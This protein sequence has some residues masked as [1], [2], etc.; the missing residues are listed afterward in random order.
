MK[1]VTPKGRLWL[2]RV[3][4]VIVVIS[5]LGVGFDLPGFRGV[6][7]LGAQVRRPTVTEIFVHDDRLDVW[8]SGRGGQD[9]VEVMNRTKDV[10]RIEYRD[11]AAGTDPASLTG[12]TSPTA[13]K[14]IVLPPLDSGEDWDGPV[15]DLRPGRYVILAVRLG[16]DGTLTVPQGAA[17]AFDVQ[18][19][20]NPTSSDPAVLTSTM[21]VE[22]R[23]T[24][25]G[26]QLSATTFEGHVDL[27]EINETSGPVI[28][29]VV[30]L[31]EG[32]D[33]ASFAGRAV[34]PSE[35]KGWSA[36]I[37]A[38][39]RAK[40]YMSYPYFPPGRYVLIAGP[41]GPDDLIVPPS[42]FAVISWK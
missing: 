4:T 35:M 22:E 14:R 13:E 31:R 30:P 24:S 39:R 7:I 26:I 23:V 16:A 15:A 42:A 2:Y 34:H 27:V 25:S 5:A 1:H 33:P 40:E 11:L 21:L 19:K 10:V 32:V 3:I 17:R 18:R 37:G 29:A 9:Y 20:A 12:A 28:I 41:A 8:S 36:V 6:L 38:G